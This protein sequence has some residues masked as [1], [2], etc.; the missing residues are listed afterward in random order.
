M[1]KYGLRKA[2]ESI[3]Y[4]YYIL[5][6]IFH[7]DYAAVCVPQQFFGEGTEED[8]SLFLRPHCDCSLLRMDGRFSAGTGQRNPHSA[9]RGKIYRTVHCALHQL[10]VCS[11]AGPA[12]PQEHSAVCTPARA[13]GAG[14]LLQ[15]LHFLRRHE[16]Q[17]QSWAV[18]LALHTGLYGIHSLQPLCGATEYPPLSV[19]RCH[20]LCAD[21]SLAAGGYFD[22][23]L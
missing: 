18:L 3:L 12:L 20:C 6:N 22:S 5:G 7:A 9:Y 13:A 8:V 10:H 19:Y 15:R 1:L 4:G 16:Q 2:Y 11:G 21:Y 23:A 17:L 14:L